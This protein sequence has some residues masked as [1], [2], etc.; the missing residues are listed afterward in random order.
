MQEAGEARAPTP[1]AIE[2]WRDAVARLSGHD[3]GDPSAF[4][5][6][7]HDRIHIP[8]LATALD[9]PPALGADLPDLP[10]FTRGV[11]AD[12]DRLGPIVRTLIDHPDPA[13][14]RT[15][16]A[17][18]LAGGASSL[19]LLVD[20]LVL[21]PR[22]IIALDLAA[23]DEVLADVDPTRTAIALDARGRGGATALTL[24]ALITR[25]RL[26]PAAVTIDFG[27]DP[28]G[29][30]AVGIPLD[31]DLAAGAAARIA[32]ELKELG[33]RGPFL[34]ADGLP[35]HQA[36]ASSAQELAA[37]LA[38]AVAY[39]RALEAAGLD[40]A[41]AAPLIGFR[42]GL[43][44]DVLTNT[45]KLR[46]ARTLWHRVASACGAD[47]G[48]MRL[49]AIGG[50]RTLSIL[51]PRINVLRSTA[52]AVAAIAGGAASLVLLPHD[53][54]EGP[55]S[56]PAR[57][58]AR[59]TQLICREESLLGLV[60][61]PFGGSFSLESLTADLAREAWS[62][63][64][65][66]E[67]GGGIAAMLR[68]GSLQDWVA[69]T[70]EARLDAVARGQELLTGVNLF[71]DL[72]EAAAR[73]PERSGEEL[74]EVARARLVSTV[75]AAEAGPEAAM[76]AAAAGAVLAFP[77][78]AAE[79]LTALRDCRL[80]TGFETLRRRAEAHRVLHGRR[81]RVGLRMLGER[82]HAEADAAEARRWFA[83]GGLEL[84]EGSQPVPLVLLC[85]EA[86][87][88]IVTEAVRAAR[89]TGVLEVWGTRPQPSLDQL[90]SAG[91][92][93][94]ALLQAAHRLLEVE[95]A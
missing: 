47:A 23:L 18:D 7:S 91:C 43:D 33:F 52:M 38:A 58:L 75:D 21:S 89:E 65:M 12:H 87:P 31:L 8:P 70:A 22:G 54:L 26:A 71:P 25:R 85:G 62:L 86:A 94:L 49:D 80:A 68:R 11:P 92:D 24:A 60:R 19:L 30:A 69:E 50:Q 5:R 78:A 2:A 95:A 83:T 53:G 13:V 28:L 41:H 51:E 76:R 44:C 81:P 61:D 20:D 64:Q 32:C 4:G 16:I 37:M 14:S 63:F 36:G 84:E 72:G 6:T 59:T 29:A 55:A 9:L 42:L 66:I 73:P 82:A 48:T 39:L 40:P 88:D 74:R 35:Y 67:G 17:A 34:R 1:Q 93:R 57:R 56:P 3:P 10:P 27:L 77:F 90:F 45:A 46:A 79:T 15:W